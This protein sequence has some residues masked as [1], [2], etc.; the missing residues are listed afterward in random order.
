MAIKT[1]IQT[2]AAQPTTPLQ[3]KF[4]TGLR[5]TLAE[6]KSSLPLNLYRILFERA[7]IW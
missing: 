5:T 2:V 3:D 1:G 6:S 7:A 4:I